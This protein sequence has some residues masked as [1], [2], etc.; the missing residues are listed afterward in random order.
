MDNG[1]GNG[2]GPGNGKGNGVGRRDFLKVL[3]A[4][5]AS[6]G[7]AGCGNG[8]TAGAEKLIPYFVPDEESIPGLAT[9]YRTTCRECPAGCGMNIRTRE[10]RAVKAEGNPLSPISHGGLCARG[11]AS[12]QGLYN[13]DRIPQALTRESGT[14]ENWRKL[15]W[16][17]AE[18]RLAAALTEAAAD[19]TVFLTHAH[20]GTMSRLL[21][22]WCNAFGI[23]RVTFDSFAREPLRAASRRVFGI[24]AVPVHDFENADMVVSFGADF[25]ETWI[26]PVDYQHGFTQSHA[27]SGGE[28]GRMVSV[29]PHMSLTDMSADHWIAARPGTEQ[30]VALAM[31]KVI[32]D[33]GLGEAG[34]TAALLAG[35]D[36]AEAAERAG[37]EEAEI[38]ETAR[39]FANGGN[40]LAAGPGVQSTHAAATALAVAV[41]VLNQVAGNIG[42]TVRYDRV[43]EAASAGSY[44]ELLA[45][46]ER[47]RAGQVDAL[48]VYGPNPLHGIPFSEELEAA[49]DRVPFMA[50]FDSYLTETAARAD[51]LLPDHHFLESWNDYEPRTGIHSLVQPVMQPVFDTKQTGDVLLSVARRAG[52]SL[53]T[54]ESTYYDYLRDVWLTEIYPRVGD[55]GSFEDWWKESLQVG[56]VALDVPVATPAFNAGGLDG[57]S[58]EPPEF[59]GGEDADYHLVVYPSYRFY[60]GRLAN[61][62]WLQ[63]LPDPVSKISWTSWVEVHPSVAEALDVDVGSMVEIETPNATGTLPVYIHPGIRPDVIA[64]Q[65]GQGHEELGRY[66][67]ERGASAARLLEP[68]VEEP[69]GAPVWIQ[70][71]ASIRPTGEWDR[72]PYTE[73]QQTQDG[74]EVARATTLEEARAGDAVRAGAIMA[75]AWPPEGDPDAGAD[76]I[77]AAAP[78]VPEQERLPQQQVVPELQDWGGFAPEDVEAGPGDYPPPGTHYGE[79]TEEEVRWGMAIDLDRC[80]GCSACVTACY[81]ENNIGMVGPEQVARGRILHWIRIE[82]YWG[83]EEEAHPEHGASFLPMLCQHCGNAP[84]EP[85][86]PVYAAYHTPEG[87]NAQVYNRCVGTRYC[88]N[89]CPYKVRV[90]NWFSWEWP[91]PL[92]WQLNP[93]VTVREKGVM[94]K[95]TMCVQRIRKAQHEARLEGRGVPDGRI[96]PACAQSCPSNVIHFGNMKDPEARVAR[97]AASG[98]AYRALDELNTQ[99]GIVYLKKVLEEEAAAVGAETH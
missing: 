30:L 44:R 98:R 69:S 48:L 11:Q 27:Y 85:V 57:L 35:V 92:N 9:W 63:E 56:V 14:G 79:Y 87:L 12:L 50:S 32:V 15:P 23:Q 99:S 24:D 84:C 43:E 62:P 16:S 18:A 45:L 71:R 46:A 97:I 31:A 42:T 10:G 91:E 95:C 51:L 36:V 65:L 17:D 83:E 40:S 41:A 59:A 8:G 3:G 77:T 38:V 82:R 81:A 26:S 2:S 20:T 88:A 61:R 47:M 4:A 60:D 7:L 37:I 34:G 6:A 74:R 33:E 55:A 80:T 86:C 39:E 28:I 49:F 76:S 67:S 13:P 58:F 89:N 1:N 22:E 29:A 94:E 5:G 96:Q 19:R 21:D 72:L 54:A 66:A 73:G 90:F 75:T 93:D 25:M 68:I 52:V 64:V 53:P 78:V 70:T